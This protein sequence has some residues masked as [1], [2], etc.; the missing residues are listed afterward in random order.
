MESE[1]EESERLHYFLPIPSTRP[2]LRV[3]S[4]SG[5]KNQ[6]QGPESNIVIGL[7]VRFCFSVTPTMQFSLDRKRWSDKQNHCSASDYV[8]LI[9]TRSLY[10]STLPITTPTTTPLL[11]KTS[12]KML[13]RDTMHG[14]YCRTDTT[15]EWLDTT[16]TTRTG[17]ETM[18]YRSYK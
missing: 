14:Q 16:R 6:C 5:R 12:P 11:V 9:F 1:L 7:F 8:G 2:S 4:R 13:T 3:G 15:R 18:V 10:H 17:H